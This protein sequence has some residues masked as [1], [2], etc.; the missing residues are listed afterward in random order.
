MPS[1]IES[2]ILD[3]Q[4]QIKA[5]EEA[6][7]RTK[8]PTI[9]DINRLLIE[10]NAEIV[11]L[12][13]DIGELRSERDHLRSTLSSTP[14]LP[15]IRRRRSVAEIVVKPH[16]KLTRKPSIISLSTTTVVTANSRFPDVRRRPAQRTL[17][18][19]RSSLF[20]KLGQGDQ[21]PLVEHAAKGE[22]LVTVRR[23]VKNWGTVDVTAGLLLGR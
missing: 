5:T 6:I 7:Y 19:R 15:A 18:K 3:L 17:H 22:V 23:G 14:K 12:R 10:F 8:Q 2:E 1:Q 20:R 11:D 9:D 21:Q 4:L 16:E 13:Q